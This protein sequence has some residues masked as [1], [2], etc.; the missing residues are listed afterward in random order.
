M[1]AAS[2]A[3]MLGNI[4]SPATVGNYE[5][6]VLKQFIRRSC[7]GG[8]CVAYK[9]EYQ[10]NENGLVDFDANGLYATVMRDENSIFPD[11]KSSEILDG[12]TFM[13]LY[14]KDGTIT[15]PYL[16]VAKVDMYTPPELCFIPLA[17]KQED[18]PGS[19]F[20]RTGY[21]YGQSYN[22][23]DIEE[24]QKVGCKITNV[25]EAI[26][27]KQSI[28]NHISKFVGELQDR[29]NAIRK[30]N[31]TIADAYKL[32]CNSFYG[33]T[34]CW[35]VEESYVFTTEKEFVK[36]YYNNDL[37]SFQSVGN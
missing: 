2:Y 35:D 5:N 22:S 3:W 6:T 26:V 32:Y 19:C 31:P 10:E 23:V 8:R 16:Y 9:A 11:I 7:H 14:L 17:T 15:I 24:A 36:D 34:V 37:I 13:D 21:T 27:F 25:H 4:V 29:R 28:P 20:Y 18:N 12:Q 30:V 33:K 1:S